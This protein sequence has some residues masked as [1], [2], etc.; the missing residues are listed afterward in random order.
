MGPQFLEIQLFLAGVEQLQ[1]PFVVDEKQVIEAWLIGEL[2]ADGFV[3]RVLLQVSDH[4]F[5]HEVR[6]AVHRIYFVAVLLE[7]R[8]DIGELLVGEVQR[9]V[10]VTD[11]AVERRTVVMVSARHNDQ[12]NQRDV[13]CDEQEKS[14]FEK[15]ESRFHDCRG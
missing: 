5:V 14:P 8:L 9:F 10:K 2:P 3:G 12:D 13:E 7:K 6:S 11:D 15:S 4:F 1:D